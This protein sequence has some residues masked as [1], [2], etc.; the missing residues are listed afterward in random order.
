VKVLTTTRGILK[1]I[2]TSCIVG[3][4]IWPFWSLV[5]F[6]SW[7]IFPRLASA[8][9]SQER[10][11]GVADA[12]EPLCVAQGAAANVSK[13]SRR[14]LRNTIDSRARVSPPVPSHRHAC[15]R[16]APGLDPAIIYHTHRS[17]PDMSSVRLPPR[18]PL[19]LRP[20]MPQHR[21]LPPHWAMDAS[22]DATTDA[23]DQEEEE[24]QEGYPVLPDGVRRL[25]YRYATTTATYHQCTH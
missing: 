11:T 14:H 12:S 17:E 23:Q 8:P 21:L 24:C 16:I 1:A 7:C 22:T 10:A 13:I 15:S 9:P 2:V 6:L 25:R 20:T 5:C 19:P 18:L 4:N 3:N